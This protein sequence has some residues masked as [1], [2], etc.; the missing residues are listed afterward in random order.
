MGIG[1]ALVVGLEDVTFTTADP[2]PACK[3][4]ALVIYELLKKRGFY[5]KALITKQAT[6]KNIFDVLN[7]AAK[8]SRAGDMFVFYFSGHGGSITDDDGD[9]TDD[10]DETLCAYD[11]HIVDDKL[12]KCWPKFRRGVRILMISDSC[13]SGTVYKAIRNQGVFLSGS[14]S[15]PFRLNLNTAKSSGKNKAS[16]MKATLLHMGGCQ[17]DKQS[18]AS[19]EISYFTKAIAASWDEGRFRGDYTQFIKSV[20]GRLVRWGVA[21][22]P[23][24]EGYGPSY[25][26]FAAQKPFA[27]EPT[28][29]LEFEDEFSTSDELDLTDLPAVETA[30]LKDD[31]P[32]PLCCSDRE[33][34][35][36]TLRRLANCLA[37][38]DTT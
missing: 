28:K 1:R 30:S 3:N 27:I 35:I 17:D 20:Y 21:Q 7:V 24:L 31:I 10:Q 23:T 8:N 29:S 15:M 13:H 25:R 33:L 9:E 32:G 11:G 19:N 12:N 5:C 38:E 26:D 37:N 22:V 34:L 36:L 4:D 2:L 16:R 14:A 6:R 18:L